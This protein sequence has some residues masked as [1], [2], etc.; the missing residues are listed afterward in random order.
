MIGIFSDT[1]GT[2][3][4][5]FDAGLFFDYIFYLLTMCM[6]TIVKRV[7]QC[8][9]YEKLVSNWPEPCNPLDMISNLCRDTF[10]N[11]SSRESDEAPNT[12]SVNEIP[13]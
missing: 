12:K 4:S 5:K 2:L 3:S 8:I 1:R 11:L 6:M 10:Y 13:N 9:A 7:G